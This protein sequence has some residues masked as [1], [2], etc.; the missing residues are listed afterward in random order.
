MSQPILALILVLRL[1]NDALECRI[2]R[3]V[4]ADGILISDDCRQ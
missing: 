4:T 1:A 3:T 2:A